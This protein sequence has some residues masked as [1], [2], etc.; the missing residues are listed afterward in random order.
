MI[1][2]YHAISSRF[3]DDGQSNVER[4]NLHQVAEVETDD[5]E[6]A[7]ERTNTIHTSWWENTGVRFLGSPEYGME[8]CRST[9]VGDV[10]ETQ[11]GKFHIVA[12]VGFR[13][14]EVS[15]EAI[16][17]AAEQSRDAPMDGDP[18]DGVS[19]HGEVSR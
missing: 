5:L 10:L 16:A 15:G 17:P 13:N 19:K 8:G 7:Y 2:V 14:V 9:S 1:K 18:D 6:V 3:F 11:D 12:S 4:S